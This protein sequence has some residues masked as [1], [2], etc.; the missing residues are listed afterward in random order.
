MLKTRS[1][2]RRQEMKS[3][4]KGTTPHSIV[5][6]SAAAVAITAATNN[7]ISTKIS[8][9]TVEIVKPKIPISSQRVEVIATGAKPKRF[10]SIAANEISAKLRKPNA[11]T[12]ELMEVNKLPNNAPSI[13]VEIDLKVNYMCE[14]NFPFSKRSYAQIFRPLKFHFI[15]FSH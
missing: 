11:K 10:D 12:V 2:D 5:K 7:T 14:P 1:S 4:M 3:E 15:F 6:N 9:R 13:K 8:K